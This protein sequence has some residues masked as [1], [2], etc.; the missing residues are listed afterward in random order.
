[1]TARKA[2]NS[3]ALGIWG[4]FSALSELANALGD[5]LAVLENNLLSIFHPVGSAEEEGWSIGERAPDC[6]DFKARI[7]STQSLLQSHLDFVKSINAR[8]DL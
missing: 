3:V 6:S 5:E 4:E 2:K 7:K 8:L 1:M